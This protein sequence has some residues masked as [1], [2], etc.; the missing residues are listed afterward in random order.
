MTDRPPPDLPALLDG[1]RAALDE[2][3]RGV[4]ALCGAVETALGTV[5]VATTS[6]VRAELVDLRQ[7]IRSVAEHLRGLLRAAGDPTRL[8]ATGAEWVGSVAGPV[9]A[10]VV[11]ASDTVQQADDHWSGAAADAYRATFLPQR[12]A[13]TAVVA[14]CSDVDVTLTDLAAAVTAFWIAIGTACLGLVLAMAGALGTAASAVG[15]PAA[16]GI[17]LAGVGALVAAGDKAL[18]SLTTIT[19]TAAA[20]SAALHR[21]LADDTAF[22]LGAWPRSTTALAGSVEWQ[23]R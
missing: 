6:C 17:A 3:A 19:A 7:A 10:V 13:L 5:P 11:V 12:N 20:R 9:S 21:R 23:V 16:A 14:A 15:A 1:V 22:P 8:R 4:D 2:A 18:S